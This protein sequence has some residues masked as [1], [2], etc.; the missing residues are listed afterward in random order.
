MEIK[1]IKKTSKQLEIE[2]IDENETLLNPVKEL[3]LQDENVDY[4]AIMT[5]HPE[6]NKRRLF[7]K[8]KKGKNAKP[9]DVLLK[10]VKKLENEVKDFKKSLKK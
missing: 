6:S 7:V 4:A 5:D 8:L 3:L 9:V 10:T 2:V 1:K